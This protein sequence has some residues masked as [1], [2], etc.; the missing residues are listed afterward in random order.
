[1]SLDKTQAERFL[2]LKERDEKNSKEIIILETKI[3]EANKNK[4]ELLKE[5]KDEYNVNSLDELREY[6]KEK[7]AEN[8]KIIADY[9]AYVEEQENIINAAN[10][11]MNDI[12]N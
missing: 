2:E 8:E 10:E 3:K 9:S 12:N 5:A 4:E 7:H 1:M 11:K 6:R